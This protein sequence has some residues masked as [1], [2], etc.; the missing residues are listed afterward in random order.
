MYHAVH[1]IYQGQFEDLEVDENRGS[2]MVFI[3]KNLD[4]PALRAGF[5]ACLST[6][7]NLEKQINALRFSLGDR[8]QC[9]MGGDEHGNPRWKS[10]T[11]VLLQYRDEDMEPGQTCPYKVRLLSI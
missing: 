1:M 10:G 6:P 7:A 4:G 9:N 3:G 11:I 5:E 8:V 2:K